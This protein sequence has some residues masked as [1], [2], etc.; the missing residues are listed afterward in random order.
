MRLAPLLLAGVC[1]LGC[2]SG[3][4]DPE[5]TDAGRIQRTTAHVDSQLNQAR[6]HIRTIDTLGV[7]AE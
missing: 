5:P 1:G 3:D 7:V 6:E 2:S 4:P